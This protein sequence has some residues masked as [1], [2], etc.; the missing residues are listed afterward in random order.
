MREIFP[1]IKTKPTFT[2]NFALAYIGVIVL[3]ISIAGTELLKLYPESKTEVIEVRVIHGIFA[4]A[5][6]FA[7]KLILKARKIEK[8]GYIGLALVGLWIAIPSLLFRIFLMENFD[9]ITNSQIQSFFA[10]QFFVSLIQAFFWIPVVI[11]LGGQRILILEAFKK[12]EKRLIISGRKEVRESHDFIVLKKEVDHAFR[13]ELII[14]TSLLLNSLNSSDDKKLSL[15]E[16]NE[17]M[18]RCLRENVLR[19]FSQRLNQ[20]SEAVDRVSNYEQDIRSLNLIRKQ[21]NILFNFTARKEPLPAWVYTLLSFAIL[22]PTYINFYTVFEVLIC[23]PGFLVIHLTAIQI[24]KILSR[25]GKYAILQL[26]L[27]T[28]L[29][30]FLPVTQLTLFNVI[31]ADFSEEFPLLISAVIYPLGF[32][33][34]MR[35]IQIIQPEAISAITDDQIYASPALKSA[36]SK[37]VKGEFKQSISHQWATFIH[38][39]ILTRLAATSLKLEQAVS[40]NDIE[41]FEAG[42]KNIVLVLE[43]PAREFEQNI[44]T[45]KSEISSRLDP[46]DGLISIKISI[47]AAL[48]N[49][50]NERVHDLGEVIEEIISNS[51]RHGGSQNISINISSSIHPDIHVQIEDDAVNPLPLVPSRIGL[52]TK[53]LNLVSDG[54]WSISRADAKTTVELTMSLFEMEA[55]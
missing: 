47:D 22:L 44:L 16:R 24:N 46:W 17:I 30:G 35:F 13:N 41:S 54:R 37:I 49:V 33:V 19:E 25:G 21:F 7:T 27:M 31:I 14:N 6:I 29:V 42:L 23:L 32:F 34:Y 36:I 15:K 9:L 26:N 3:E 39:K 5:L 12:Y 38:G 10:K 55:R 8:T 18:Q 28:L 43:D 48:E 52:G 53:I 4:F 40:N 50:S 2:L 51:V 1:S 11:I 20:K 45:L